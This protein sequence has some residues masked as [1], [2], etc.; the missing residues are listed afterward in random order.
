MSFFKKKDSKDNEQEDLHRSVVPTVAEESAKIFAW[1]EDLFQINAQDV[2]GQPKST[3]DNMPERIVLRTVYGKSGQGLGPEI[4][5]EAWKPTISPLPSREKLVELSN[6]FFGRAQQDAIALKRLQLYGLFAYS[7]LKGP[8]AY[9]RYLFELNMT[10]ERMANPQAL[11]FSVPASDD[12]DTH[13]DRLLATSLAHAR[14]QQEQF[15]ESI[16]GVLKL[17]NTLIQQLM[18][19]RTR[20]ETERREMMIA[21][22]EALSKKQEREIA[23]Q[24]AQAKVALL[25][26]GLNAVKGLIPAIAIHLSKGKSGIVEG[27]QEFINS[28]SDEQKLKMFG[29]WRDGQCVASGIFDTSQIELLDAIASGKEEPKR[30]NDFIVGLRPDQLMAAQSV[31]TQNQINA[32]LALAKAAGSV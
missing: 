17:Q 24:W 20:L 15:S 11:I 23:A 5:S 19:D 7:N 12:D 1:L 18:E 6:K 3:A 31:L 14:W 32:L 22:E 30:V 27:I 8:G 4:Y 25:N 2:P 9:Q 13:R 21:T 26:E 29:Q 28:L 16:S 10:H